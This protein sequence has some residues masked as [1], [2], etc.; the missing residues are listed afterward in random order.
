MNLS[1]WNWVID[2]A[3]AAALGG[4]VGAS[5]IVNRY[6]DAP[7]AAA[8]TLPARFYIALN[9]LASL[10]ALGLI[11]HN[12]WFNDR[13]TQ[14]LMAG[15]SAMAFFRS[16]LFI[17]RAGDKDIG[18][19]PSGFLQIFLTSADRAVDRIRAAARSKA[20]AE[21]MKGV[22]YRKAYNSLPEYCLA[23]MQSLSDED[24]QQLRRDLETLDKGAA[25][26]PVKAQ[27]LGLELIN[28]VGE[29]VLR[30]AVTALG[31]EIR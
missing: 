21:I 22:D 17:I 7:E 2:A 10:T 18:V 9:A 15:V 6:R 30:A 31:D 28:V 29:A 14:V 11:H 4:V 24:Q 16:S 25:E 27:L 13:W 8:S 20:A 26:P 1:D 3:I 19:G 5:E 23:L 12:H